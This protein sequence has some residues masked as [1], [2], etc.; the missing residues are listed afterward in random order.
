MKTPNFF[1][2]VGLFFILC[3]LQPT[4]A[5]PLEL[6]QLDDAAPNYVVI[7]AFAKQTN[8]MR[9]TNHAKRDVKLDARFEMN[10]RRNLYYVYVLTTRELPVAIEE[11]KRL[12]VESEYTDTWVYKGS[13]SD[14]TGPAQDIVLAPPAQTGGEATMNVASAN[15]PT[16]TQKASTPEAVKTNEAGAVAAASTVAAAGTSP[17]ETASTEPPIEEAA[18][19][20]VDDG[21]EGTKFFFKITRANDQRSCRAMSTLSTWTARGRWAPI[22]PTPW[23][24]LRHRPA[25]PATCP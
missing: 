11:A 4:S 8:A 1:A 9:F 19:A 15:S 6:Q 5:A 21:T 14:L 22:K 20:V 3:L 25:S 7:G 23:L 17:L 24:K 16:G 2:L 12:R 13:L 10:R 18:D